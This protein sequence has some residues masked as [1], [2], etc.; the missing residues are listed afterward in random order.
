MRH[1]TMT[2]EELYTG[3]TIKV[4]IT[5]H[6][7]CGKCGGKGGDNR[8]AHSKSTCNGMCRDPTLQLCHGYDETGEGIGSKTRCQECNNEKVVV[9]RKFL[10]IHVKK[11]MRNGETIKICGESD[12]APDLIPGDVLVVIEEE[13]HPRFVREGDDLK[14]EVEIDPSVTLAGGS[15]S[16]RQLDGRMLSVHIVSGTKEGEKKNHCMLRNWSYNK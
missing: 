12:R 2:L 6:V 4:P 7:I 3:K 8:T 15:I 10:E 14:T 11:G 13:W 9:E 16:I 1:A 5:R